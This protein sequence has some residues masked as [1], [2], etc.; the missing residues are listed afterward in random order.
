MFLGMIF[1]IFWLLEWLDYTSNFIVMVSAASYYFDSSAAKDGQAT[2]SLGFR[3][4]Y[5]NHLGSIAFASLIM[6]IIKMIQAIFTY[7]ANTASEAS[8][9]NAMVKM[10]IACG[11]CCLKCLEKIGDYINLSALAYMACSG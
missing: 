10:A 1:G 3:F 6:A 4:A 5:Y 7:M 9:D 8:G 2:V 11:A